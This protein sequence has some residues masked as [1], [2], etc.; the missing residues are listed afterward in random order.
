MD[1][2]LRAAP[3]SAT[4]WWMAVEGLI[5]G[6][7][8]VG[9]CAL[10]VGV[11]R[12]SADGAPVGDEKVEVRVKSAFRELAK[13]GNAIP[14][15]IAVVVT[16]LL[17]WWL[18]VSELK[19]QAV[20][21]VTL[22]ILAGVAAGRVAAFH[23]PPQVFMVAIVVLAVAA[24]ACTA[25]IQGGNLLEVTYQNRLWPIARPVPLDWIAGGLLGA[26]IGLAWAASLVE[27]QVEKV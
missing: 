23:T 10:I 21:G 1:D 26:P 20:L 15:A 17:S 6:L 12:R 8:A 11:A 27:R 18:V 14:I 25:A 16:G 22:A 5:F 4:L 3:S 2:I 7:L 13:P 24:P 19:G 9:M